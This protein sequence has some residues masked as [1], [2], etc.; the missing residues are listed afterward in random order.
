MIQ[1]FK[2]ECA[3]FLFADRKISKYDQDSCS[4]QN[5]ETV[6][7]GIRKKYIEERKK[8]KMVENFPGL[9]NKRNYRGSSTT[10]LVVATIVLETAM[11]KQFM[12]QQSKTIFW[13]NLSAAEIIKKINKHQHSHY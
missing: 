7:R 4:C 10:V 6:C 9:I 13:F 3:C 1:Q 11:T 2:R 5:P 8:H 12:A